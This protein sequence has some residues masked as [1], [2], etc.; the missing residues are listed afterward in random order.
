M[1]EVIIQ[2]DKDK[3][4][5]R[6]RKLNEDEI[7]YLLIN[8]YQIQK[9]KDLLTNQ[10]EKFVLLPRNN[11]TPIH[12]FLI[13][14]ITEYLRKNGIEVK[15]YA[16]KKPDMV[17]QINKKTYA[18]EVETGSA[19][20]KIKNFHEKIKLLNA[21]YDKWFFVI[22]KRNLVKKFRG[23]GDSVDKRY[24]K[25]RLDKLIKLSK[26]RSPIFQG[27]LKAHRRKNLRKITKSHSA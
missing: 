16:T 22:T 20:S 18:I 24:V 8:G 17:F 1:K 6:K 3:R 11:E 9:Y 23:F 12:F 2:V 26:N 13:K 21:N 7:K 14:N 4:Y 25:L 19:F 5:F 27:V 10:M 15:L